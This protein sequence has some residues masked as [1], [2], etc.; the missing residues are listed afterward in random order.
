MNIAAPAA[1]ATRIF[2]GL[3]TQEKGRPKPPFP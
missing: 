3:I 2:E 1:D